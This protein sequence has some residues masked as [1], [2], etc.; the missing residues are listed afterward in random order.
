MDQQTLDPGHL[1]TINIGASVP[2]LLD[3]MARWCIKGSG[4]LTVPSRPQFFSVNINA[5]AV[6][7]LLIF[8]LIILR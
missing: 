5:A 1:E 2:P 7:N 3:N 8:T 6:G 4:R